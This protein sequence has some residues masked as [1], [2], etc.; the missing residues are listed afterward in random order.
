MCVV[1]GAGRFPVS[2]IQYLANLTLFNAPLGVENVDV[3]YW[4]LWAELRFYGVVLALILVGLTR[5]RV[6]GALWLWLG[7]ACVTASGVLPALLSRLLEVPVQ[8]S[9]AHY[10]VAGMALCLVTKYGPTRSTVLLVLGSYALALHH[11]TGFAATV[12]DRYDEPLSPVVATLAITLIFLV[13]TGIATGWT[14]R[15]GR[16]RFVHAGALTYPLH[17]H[18]GFILFNLFADTVE[19]HV[20]LTAVIAAMGAA[21]YALHR[22]VERPLT[23]VLLHRLQG[24]P[25]RHKAR[26][27]RG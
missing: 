14:R 9:W 18:T 12:A 5:R 17:A 16:G 23:G 8:S 22:L 19:P 3:V 24:S 7:A 11:A 6:T 21:A 20:L 15:L 26:H 13:M 25:G 1:L 10:F 4:T 2:G 27:G